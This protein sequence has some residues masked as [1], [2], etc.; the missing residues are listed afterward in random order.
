MSLDSCV[1]RAIALLADDIRARFSA[2]PLGVL[3]DDLG[4]IVTPVEHLAEARNGGGA[5]DGMS[6][7]QDQVI[8]YAPTPQS[9]RENFTLAHE[10]GHWLVE[11]ADGIYDWVAD[12]DEPGRVLETICDRIAQRLLLPDEVVDQVVVAG[13]VRA[14]HVLDLY[15]ATQASRPVCA[16]ALAKRLP[17]LGAVA[18]IN[19]DTRTVTHASVTPDPERGWPTVFPWPGQD[20]PDGHSLLTLPVAGTTTRRLQWRTQWGSQAYFYVDAI[21]EGKRI[22]AVFAGSDIWGIDRFPVNLDREFDSRP[23]LQVHCCG[24]RSS[25][26]GYPCPKCQQPFCP[27]CGHC[28][29]ERQAMREVQCQ[30]CFLQFQPHL[31]INGLCQECRD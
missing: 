25:T 27:H 6:F 13:P 5:C 9:R 10:F 8:L 22:V 26:R 12:Q 16:I 29:C 11:R 18:L 31:V 2:D 28:R 14:R 19:R 15:A 21:G 24:T 17:G 4:L 1:D 3:R 7:L 20:L 23:L 30:G